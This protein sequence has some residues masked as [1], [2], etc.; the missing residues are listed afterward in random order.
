VVISA[1]MTPITE[2]KNNLKTNLKK[3]EA[4]DKNPRAQ[5]DFIYKNAPHYEEVHLQLPIFKFF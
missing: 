5:L 3:E 1:D 2:L 4:F